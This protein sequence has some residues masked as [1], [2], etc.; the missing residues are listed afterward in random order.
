MSRSEVLP[1]VAGWAGRFPWGFS[2]LGA[3]G[4]REKGLQKTVRT[5]PGVPEPS[6]FG[7]AEKAEEPAEKEGSESQI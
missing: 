1:S 4:E 2:F 3:K 6:N 7:A 5:K